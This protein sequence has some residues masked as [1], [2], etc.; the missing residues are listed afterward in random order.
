MRAAIGNGLRPAVWRKFLDRFGEH[1]NIREIY[2]ATEG[3][4]GFINLDNHLGSIGTFSPLMK[5][6]YD[7]LIR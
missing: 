2:A 5:V 1:I 4:V 7:F 3:N 6:R